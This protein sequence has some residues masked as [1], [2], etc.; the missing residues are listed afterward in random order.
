MWYQ[1]FSCMLLQTERRN[2]DPSERA[3]IAASRSKNEQ[4]HDVCYD[5]AY[6]AFVTLLFNACL[7][8]IL[9]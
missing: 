9:P 2:Y 8:H 7:A 6:D 3:S 5:T 1:N 4:L